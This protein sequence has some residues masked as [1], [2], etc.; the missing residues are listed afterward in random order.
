LGSTAC[1]NKPDLS[2]RIAERGG[3][4]LVIEQTASPAQGAT[5]NLG[6]FWVVATEVT[7]GIKGLTGVSP[8]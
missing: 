2:F 6:D 7:N 8:N 3:V 4:P 1:Q 5:Q